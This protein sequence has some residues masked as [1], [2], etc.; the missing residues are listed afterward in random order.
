MSIV[1]VY[2]CKSDGTR[3]SLRDT[4][5]DQT[6]IFEEMRDHTAQYHSE[7]KELK[8]VEFCEKWS[9]YYTKDTIED[10]NADTTS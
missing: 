7:V 4:H 9:E 1:T 5:A 3:F 10:E 2:T 6:R 8:T